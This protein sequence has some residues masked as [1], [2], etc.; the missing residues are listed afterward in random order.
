[1]VDVVD[2]KQVVTNSVQLIE[3]D[4]NT[5][6]KED[7]NFSDPFSIEAKHDD[8]L[9][10]FVTFVCEEHGTVT[11]RFE[12]GQNPRNN[13]DLDFTIHPAGLRWW[14]L[15]TPSKEHVPN[16]LEFVFTFF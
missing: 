11:G 1:M 5:M 12:L 10:A 4:L 7:V 9:Y 8:Y 6:K 13:Q 3:I 15:A 14:A 2:L 16:L